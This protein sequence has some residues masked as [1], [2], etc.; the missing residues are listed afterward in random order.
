MPVLPIASVSLDTDWAVACVSRGRLAYRGSGRFIAI[1]TANPASNCKV[2]Q[3]F[4]TCQ[5]K[6]TSHQ[7]NWHFFRRAALLLCFPNR[8]DAPGAGI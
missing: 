3:G 7:Q 2:K 1:K 5:E 4:E 8:L 6:S